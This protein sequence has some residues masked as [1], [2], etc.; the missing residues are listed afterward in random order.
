MKYAAKKIDQSE[1]RYKTG[2]QISR[3]DS[4]IKKA[5]NFL[6]DPNK[7]ERKSLSLCKPCYYSEGELAGQAMCSQ[8]CGICGEDQ[9]YSSTATHALCQKCACENKLCKRCAADVNLNPS[10]TYP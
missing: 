6:H 7:K 9:L 5:F 4:V 8:P 3:I 1:I 10:R 2:S